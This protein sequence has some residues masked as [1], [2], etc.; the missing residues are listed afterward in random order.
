LDAFVL[1]T[2]LE[3]EDLAFSREVGAR[4]ARLRKERGI[5][6]KEMAEKLG[7]SQ[8]HVSFYENGQLRLHAEVLAKI[9][10]IL[11]VASDEILG[12]ASPRKS[13]SP[14]IGARKFSRIF[15]QVGQLPERDQ[16]AVARLIS[17]LVASHPRTG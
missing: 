14:T 2:K 12:L 3:E 16:R 7:I 13:S 4:V 17:S 8:P 6:Q 10:R 11:G 15:L 5:T 1:K 9:S